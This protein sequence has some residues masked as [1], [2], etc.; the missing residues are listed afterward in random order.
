MGGLSI[1]NNAQLTQ[2]GSHRKG[3]ILY[4]RRD[5]PA[6]ETRTGKFVRSDGRCQES[7]DIGILSLKTLDRQ[8][9]GW[10]T[11]ARSTAEP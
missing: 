9:R 4:N 10:Y 11:P 8:M 2:D 7:K 6:S 5:A 1:I 3:M